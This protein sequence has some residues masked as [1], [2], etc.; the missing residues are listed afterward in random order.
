MTQ[1]NIAPPVC[2]FCNVEMEPKVV[3]GKDVWRCPVCKRQ[4]PADLP[5][6]E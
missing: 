5:A 3:F 1:E 6:E 4:I 2:V